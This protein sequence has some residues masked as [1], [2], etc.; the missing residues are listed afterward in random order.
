VG[1]A[2]ALLLGAGAAGLAAAPAGA[3]VVPR[4]V[5]A[6]SATAVT[7]T[8]GTPLGGQ[9]VTIAGAGFTGAT[10]VT[11][12]G[13]PATAFTVVDDTT[14]TATT[15]AHTSGAVDVVVQQPTGDSAP[16]TY[17]YLA[18]P[19]IAYVDYNRV[20]EAGGTVVHLGGSGFTGA[21]GVTFGG[22]AAPTFTVTDDSHIDVTTPAHAPGV[23][24]VVVQSPNGDSA[25]SSITYVPVTTAVITSI[26]PDHGVPNTNPTVTLTGTGFL[27]TLF[28]WV[29]GTVSFT[30][31]SDTTLTY[32]SPLMG[33]GTTDVKIQTATGWS[34][35]V[36]FTTGPG[37]TIASVSPATAS[38]GD[39]VTLTGSCFTN[40]TG[41]QFGSTPAQ[42]FAVE[43]DTSLRAIVPAGV[44]TVDVTVQGY[45]G[46]RVGTLAA[47]FTYP[48]SA[49]GTAD[50]GDTLADTGSSAP[51][52][53]LF[54]AALL[55]SAGGA[56]MIA[57]RVRRTT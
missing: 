44:G 4:I 20:S 34:A 33:P 25:A 36:T 35:P 6:A 38:P 13:T 39:T 19:T 46:C 5:M 30:I 29:D 11:F 56:L 24:D 31:V 28:V 47:A 45:L 52:V 49:A 26:T 16:L 10:G 1:A 7:P 2:L 48:A 53:P 37:T 14:I 22:T 42:Y 15:P 40:A 12:G 51:L 54:A 41:V 55:L 27:G 17:T 57:R 50:P 32:V 8:S 23:V 21:T 18:A 43:S 3:A 9:T